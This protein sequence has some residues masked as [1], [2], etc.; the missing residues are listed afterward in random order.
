MFGISKKMNC[1]SADAVVNELSLEILLKKHEYRKSDYL[2][3]LQENHW[4]WIFHAE[5]M[6]LELNLWK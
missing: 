1:K 2:F 5:I 6:I 3:D 4:N